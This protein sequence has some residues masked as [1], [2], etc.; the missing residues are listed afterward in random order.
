MAALGTQALSLLSSHPQGILAKGSRLSSASS[1]STAIPFFTGFRGD[2]NVKAANA[3]VESCAFKGC[4]VTPVASLEDEET[5]AV[6]SR[7]SVLAAS[8]AALSLGALSGGSDGND[9]ALADETISSWEQVT[10]PVDPGV[11]LLDMAF[12]PD[13]PDRGMPD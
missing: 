7:R 9:A 10:L 2:S 4:V 5:V 3:P 12:V 8:T 6:L 13:Q 1:S 11:V